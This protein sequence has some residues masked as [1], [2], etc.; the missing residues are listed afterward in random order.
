MGI[1]AAALRTLLLTIWARSR[2]KAYQRV[3]GVGQVLQTKE[4]ITKSKKKLNNVTR[5]E[6]A[7]GNTLCYKTLVPTQEN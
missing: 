6:R 4:I 2:G 3:F 7:N 1:A 5:S